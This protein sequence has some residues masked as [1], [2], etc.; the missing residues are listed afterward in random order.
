[1]RS[2]A[3]ARSRGV[4]GARLLAA[5]AADG[6]VRSIR[7]IAA[8]HG[9]DRDTPLDGDVRISTGARGVGAT[10]S[11]QGI[12][13][14]DLA[15][16]ASIGDEFVVARGAETLA[17][18]QLRDAATSDDAR[19]L[20][21]GVA[22]RGE[23]DGVLHVTARLL[24]GPFVPPFADTLR[25]EVSDAKG[26]PIDALVDPHVDGGT[27]SVTT[28]GDG[29]RHAVDLLVTPIAD[30][31]EVDASARTPDGRTGSF[32]GKLPTAMG[33]LWLSP[34]DPHD[35]SITVVS[36]APHDRAFVSLY[37][38][39]RRLGGHVVKLE[40]RSDGFH[41]GT[42]E[43]SDREASARYAVLATD[44]R[45]ASRAA[46]VWALEPV[47][48]G[49]VHVHVRRLAV[50]L[51]GFPDAV[52]KET[53]RLK[54]V[55][56]VLVGFVVLLALVEI[57]LLGTVAKRARRDAT[58]HFQSALDADGGALA[59]PVQPVRNTLFIVGVVTLLVGLATAALVAL[60]LTSR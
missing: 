32:S 39:E 37:D 12:A 31:I 58:L 3:S 5:P 51:D 17:R 16:D 56:R 22:A 4:D 35:T 44:E 50:V 11:E 34:T 49:G 30:Q 52:A 38:E 25:L 48:E 23:H 28:K 36:A 14:V 45:E 47:G 13:D 33:A 19:F 29:A 15:D 7:L 8:R 60:T 55:H 21:L 24:R 41:A 46:T 53:G 9:D 26:A 1:M 40:E 2:S 18:G 27:F 10:L 54:N 6:R 43:R 57:V 59:P 20:D 42:F